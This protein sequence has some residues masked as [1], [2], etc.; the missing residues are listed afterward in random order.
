MILAQDK[1][2]LKNLTKELVLASSVEV[3]ETLESRARGLLGR[4]SIETDYCLWIHKC[5]SIHTF[6]MKFNIDVIFVDKKLKVTSV[7]ININKWRLAWGGFFADSC[8]EFKALSLSN[9]DVQK[10]DILYVGN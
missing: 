3:A 4:E 6:F 2:T 8:F 10:G 5:R 1:L 7:K 9:E